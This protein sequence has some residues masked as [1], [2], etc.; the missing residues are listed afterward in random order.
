[1][2]DESQLLFL[3][4]ASG[5]LTT[6]DAVKEMRETLT[7]HIRN[8]KYVRFYDGFMG[9]MTMDALK[10]LGI[11]DSMPAAIPNSNRTMYITSVPRK[12]KQVE[13]LKQWAT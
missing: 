2:I 6:R 13:F 3:Q 1:M 5:T 8:A 11:H 9:R 10:G 12:I 7:F 4:A